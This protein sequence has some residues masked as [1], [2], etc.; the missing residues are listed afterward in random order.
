[1]FLIGGGGTRH[2]EIREK[3]R[4]RGHGDNKKKKD[5]DCRLGLEAARGEPRG[6]RKHIIIVNQ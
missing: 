2:G 1:M 4:E 3:E 5:S 6:A